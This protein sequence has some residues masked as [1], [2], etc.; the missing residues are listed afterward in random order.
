MLPPITLKLIAKGFA[1]KYY[2]Q[3]ATIYSASSITALAQLSAL[4][5]PVPVSVWR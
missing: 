5:R 3:A 2:V 4:G 1:L